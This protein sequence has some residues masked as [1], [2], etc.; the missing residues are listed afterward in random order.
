MNKSILK[1]LSRNARPDG[2]FNFRWILRH[3]GSKDFRQ[4]QVCQ[5]DDVYQTP[6]LLERMRCLAEYND[7]VYGRVDKSLEPLAKTI[8]SETKELELLDPGSIPE[9]LD[10]ENLNRLNALRET[11]KAANARRRSEILIHMSE[12][13]LYLETLDTAL[14]HHLEKAENVVMRHVSSYWSGVLKA[15]AD[16]QMPVKPDVELPDVPGKAVY[17][18]HMALLMETINN[19][20]A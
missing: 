17:E 1:E 5:K 19:V 6:N 20:I 16:P 18:T 3:K 12:I 7:R 2:R 11:R 8:A 9:G 4:S 15:A 13:R 10:Q 14:S